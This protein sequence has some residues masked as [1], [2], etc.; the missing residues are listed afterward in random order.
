MAKTT[1]KVTTFEFFIRCISVKKKASKPDSHHVSNVSYYLCTRR[2]QGLPSV[3]CCLTHCRVRRER[4][5]SSYFPLTEEKVADYLQPNP[6]TSPQTCNYSHFLEASL[7]KR[8]FFNFWWTAFVTE[9]WEGISYVAPGL[10]IGMQLLPA[11]FLTSVLANL[12]PRK[13]WMGFYDFTKR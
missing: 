3:L 13:V 6:L 9:E 8:N 4:K 1:V 10:R 12:P 11:S 5:N 2:H 7:Y